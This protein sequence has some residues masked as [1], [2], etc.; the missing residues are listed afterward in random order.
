MGRRNYA[1][2][3]IS[4]IPVEKVACPDDLEADAGENR[5]FLEDTMDR[6]QYTFKRYEKKFVLTLKQYE[7]LVSLLG[8]YMKEDEYGVHTIGNIYYDTDDYDLVRTSIEKPPYKEKFRLRSYGIPDDNSSIFAEIKKKF[9]G[10]VY[11]RRVAA[12]PLEMQ[13]FLNGGQIPHEDIQIQREIYW[14][15][16]MF[17]LT[18]KVFIGYERIAFEGYE[19]PDLR[20]TFDRNIRWRLEELD[21]RCGT[22]GQPVLPEERIVMEIKLPQTFPLWLAAVL[23]ELQIY[24]TGF[25]KYGAC[26]QRHIAT[27]LFTERKKFVC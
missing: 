14:F 16:H 18:P 17:H 9:D 2:W 7:A 10:V 3:R 20:I 19:N 12:T 13:D 4:R 23:S 22:E 6:V 1:D 26:Y 27:N 8:N 21:F 25:S 11:K 24:S 5:I 15:L